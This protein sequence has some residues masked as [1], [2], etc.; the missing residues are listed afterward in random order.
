MERGTILLS[1]PPGRLSDEDVA[2]I[3]AAAPE[4]RVVLTRDREAIRTMLDE[5]EIAAGSFPRDLFPEAHNLRWYQQWWTGVDW[6]M[7]HPE[8]AGMDFVLT[9]TS[10]MQSIPISEHVFGLLLCFARDLHRAVRAQA[11]HEWISFRQQHLFE[12]ARQRLLLVGVGAIGVR[13]ARLAEALGMEVWGV[14]NHP[15]RDAPHVAAMFGPAQLLELLPQVDSVVVTVPLTEETRG[16]IGARELQA[17]KRSAHL[18]NVG[19]GGVIEEPALI[20]ALEAG[21]I[22]GAGLD[23]FEEEPLPA[24]SPLWDMENVIVSSHYAGLTP[25]YNERALEI[26]L[27]NLDRYRAGEPLKNVVDKKRG[28]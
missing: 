2:R 4:T 6:L 12:L 27:D 25:H 8:V 13:V 7:R 3:R 10:G 14:R 23:V 19:R 9:N 26:F 18:I 20:R 22:A 28:Y 17:M 5:V 21:E 1:F 16:M 11:R 24:D 15:E